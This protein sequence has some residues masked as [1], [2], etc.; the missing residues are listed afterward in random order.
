MVIFGWGQHT[1]NDRKSILTL[2]ALRKKEIR[3][4]LKY[5]TGSFLRQSASASAGLIDFH[6]SNQIP[7]SILGNEANPPTR[8]SNYDKV[9]KSKKNK[10][11]FRKPRPLHTN[12]K[13]GLNHFHEGLLVVRK[14]RANDRY[15]IIASVS[16]NRP[17]HRY[18]VLRNRSVR[19]AGHNKPTTA[20]TTNSIQ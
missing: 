9:K 19:H 20:T 11:P 5:R 15:T 17:Q 8:R 4:E 1:L 6:F 3:L 2:G 14:K 18:A 12:D 16:R 7:K 13:K 10:E